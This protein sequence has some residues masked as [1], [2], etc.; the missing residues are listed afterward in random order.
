MY[1]FA[2]IILALI[3]FT[4]IVVLPASELIKRE[5]LNREF[6]NIEVGDIYIMIDDVNNPYEDHK[7]FVIIA[8]KSVGTNGNSKWVKYEYKRGGGNNV[9]NWNN[10]KLIYVKYGNQNANDT[11]SEDKQGGYSDC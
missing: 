10:F 5:K 6:R 9:M 4:V 1:V 7:R 11:Q 2:F 8:D 3:L